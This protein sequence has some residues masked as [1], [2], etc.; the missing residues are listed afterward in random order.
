MR[1]LFIM[2]FLFMLFGFCPIIK[3]QDLDSICKGIDNS[4]ECSKAI[5]KHQLPIYKDY[6]FRKGINLI[7]KLDNG[8]TKKIF[9]VNVDTDSVIA[10][11]FRDYIKSINSYL[12]AIQYYE[13]GNFLIIDKATGKSS[14]I[15]GIP[16]IS[17]NK[18]RFVA[19]NLDVLS[20]YNANGY[21]IYRMDNEKGYIKEYEEYPSDWGP[22]NVKWVNDNE[23]E[24]EK[25]KLD[26]SEN[27]VN[28][29]SFR[30]GF[31][32]QWNRK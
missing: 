9:D 27:L 31:E 17:K 2:F 3:A 24:I 7:F 19:S 22:S 32:K 30:L 8:V 25:F 14:V 4:Y 5:E 16:I 26:S 1:T 23:I 29:G 15:I 12:L 18:T 21:Q 20:Q 11:C 10:Y 28:F 13:G 6:V